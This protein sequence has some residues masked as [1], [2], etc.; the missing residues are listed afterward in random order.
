MFRKSENGQAIV[1]LAIGLVVLL[2]F[3]A[4][5]IDAG[6]A[7]TA[8]REAQ[9]AVDAAVLAGTRQL[10]IECSYQGTPAGSSESNIRNKIASMATANNADGTLQAYYT[11]DSGNRLSDNEVGTLGAVPCGCG[12]G[13]ARG[14]EV[15]ASKVSPSFFSGL[16]GQESIEVKA[17]AKARY[18]PV[19]NVGTGLY[20][21]TRQHDPNL[22]YNQSVTLRIV[23][24]PSPGNFGWL[25][26]NG[27][28]NVPKLAASLEAPG[29]A[30]EFY[31][32]PGTP[33]NGWTA[34]HSD[35]LIQV[36]KWVQGATGNMNSSQVRGWLDWHIANQ[37]VMVIPLYET[38]IGQGANYNYKVASFAGFVLES[39]DL[40]G[41]N[42]SMTGRFVKWVTNGDWAAGVTC[43]DEMGMYSVKLTP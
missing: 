27:E 21:F 25:T 3:S 13:S 35:K 11:D 17:T 42:K 31:Y 23:D 5:A 19:A 26:W 20:P 30:A 18:A 40:T 9:N 33:D 32:N 10:V 38:G 4:L 15:T 14:I 24:E 34:D 41:Q 43:D 1:I 7:Y 28:T 36:G 39:Y 16:I 6:S 2:I 12:A 22:V 37:D 29:D 8:K